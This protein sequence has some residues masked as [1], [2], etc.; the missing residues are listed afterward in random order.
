M[1]AMLF[2]LRC[3]FL[4][5]G[6]RC[7]AATPRTKDSLGVVA[8]AVD[9][10]EPQVDT[11]AKRHMVLDGYEGAVSLRRAGVS[12]EA[13]WRRC[14]HVRLR[15]LH[16]RRCAHHQLTWHL[17]SVR[18]PLLPKR[19]PGRRGEQQFPGQDWIYRAN[20][21]GSRW[22]NCPIHPCPPGRLI[23]G[24]PGVV[25]SLQG[26]LPR[27]V[28]ITTGFT[29]TRHCADKSSQKSLSGR[30]VVVSQPPRTKESANRPTHSIGRPLV[31]QQDSRAV[32][33]TSI[34]TTTPP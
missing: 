4:A 28:L 19:R 11:W 17:A 10:G 27:R 25:W 31:L 7:A 33:S 34:R 5:P 2:S 14:V 29:E 23:N 15:F 20:E 1:N 32:E 18:T 21:T 13:V 30:G 26:P 8:A 22:K 16:R 24:R 12:I 6:P 9:G 3:Y